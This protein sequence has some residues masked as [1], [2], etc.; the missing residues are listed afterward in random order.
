MIF[1]GVPMLSIYP[2]IGQRYGMES[3]CAAAM[4]ATTVISFITISLMIWLVTR[5][6]L[7]AGVG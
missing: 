7:V 2:I 1:A 6:G 4:V 3:L 5:I